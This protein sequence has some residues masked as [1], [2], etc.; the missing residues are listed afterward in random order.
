MRV[1]FYLSGS[2]PVEQVLPLIARA[3]MKGG[4]RMLVTSGDAG[5]LDQLEKALWEVFPADF[6]ANGR[7]EADYADRQPILLSSERKADNGAK[8]LALADGVWHEDAEGF[9]RVLFFFDEEGRQ[10]ARSNWKL[11]DG[12]EDVEREFYELIEGKWQ[13]KA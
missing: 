3:A 13:R 1:G 6:L 9:D 5:Q 2:R 7:A 4:Q 12:R 8:L 11:F 10:A